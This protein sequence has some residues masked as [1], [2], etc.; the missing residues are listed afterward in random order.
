[1]E[2][3]AVVLHK[4]ALAHY[5]VG[6]DVDELYTARLITYGGAACNKPP[7]HLHFIEQGRHCSG[8]TNNQELIDDLWY[9]AKQKLGGYNAP[10]QQ[11]PPLR[12]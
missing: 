6:K 8:D 1:M 7:K 9:T 11:D 2:V 12:S 5:S 4:G 10:Q 3:T